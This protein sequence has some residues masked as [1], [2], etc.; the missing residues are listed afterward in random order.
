METVTDLILEGSKIIADGDCIHE[1]KRRLLLGKKIMT[2]LDSILKSRDITL[3]TKIHLVKAMAF[4]VVTYG[5]ER[6]KKLSVKEL[7]LFNCGVGEDS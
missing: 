1:I 6:N 3:S 5:C 2:N 7:M 4:P